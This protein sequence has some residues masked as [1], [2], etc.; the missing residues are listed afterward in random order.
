M[1]ARHRRLARGDDGENVYTTRRPTA[2]S[3]VPR[4]R[5]LD[6][7]QIVTLRGRIAERIREWD[8]ARAAHGCACPRCGGKF[9]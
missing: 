2:P 4:A 5:T 1:T 9:R 7:R 6:D 8:W 3:D